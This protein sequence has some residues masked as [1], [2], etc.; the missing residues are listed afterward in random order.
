MKTI[1]P[2]LTIHSLRKVSLRLVCGIMFLGLL[3]GVAPS[4]RA[5]IL[6]E[7]SQMQF[8]DSLKQEFY[9]GPYFGLYKDNYFSVG[10]TFPGRPTRTNS[11]VKFQVS[12]AQRLT[13]NV[14]PWGSYLFLMYT[15]K[16]F[17]NVFEESMPMR[18]LNFNPGIGLSKPFFVKGRYS[19]KMTLM[20]EHESNGKDGPASRSWNKISLSGSALITK[21]LMVHAKYW[22]PIVDGMNNKDILKYSGI[23]QCG[24]EVSAH[25]RRYIWAATL[26]K[27]KGWNLNFNTNL[28]FSMRIF[29]QDNQ[30]LFFQF[31]NGYGENMLDYNQFHSRLRVGISIKPRFFSE[32]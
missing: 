10:T 4:L 20:V 6:V 1:L 15:Q 32:F 25:D 21:W 22:Y 26:V 24:V 27:R 17:W 12:I 31:Y 29:K 28:E 8:E 5:Q 16:T 19:G 30:Y 9:Y 13:N 3:S 14:L 11:D 18:D 23:Y 2:I 7:P